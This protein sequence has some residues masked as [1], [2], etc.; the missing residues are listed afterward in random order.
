[1]SK[2]HSPVRKVFAKKKSKDHNT[3]SKWAGKN[4]NVRL[5]WLVTD[6]EA[7]YRVKEEHENIEKDAKKVWGRIGNGQRSTD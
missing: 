1:M 7:F 6:I 5:R 4:D 2:T 3:R